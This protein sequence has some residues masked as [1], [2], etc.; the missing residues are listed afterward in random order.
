M[1]LGIDVETGG[2][3]D[4]VSLLTVYL[5]VLD[6]DFEVVSDLE[7][8]IKPKDGRYHVTAEALAVNKINLIEH[9]TKAITDS[10]AGP[11]LHNWLKEASLNGAVKLVPVGQNVGFDIRV[12][13]QKL[14]KAPA[15]E[16]FVSYRLLDTAVIAQYLKVLGKI[17]QEVSGGLGTLVDHYKVPRLE[18][19]VA[20]NDVLM[21]VS[22]LK[23]MLKE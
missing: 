5:A 22:V 1:Y 6:Q 19:H 12:L 14:L 17:P 4:D 15:W 16:K 10:E 23:A 11:I 13:Q 21:T 9:D 7:L 8:N 18:A 3:G 2:I 20:K